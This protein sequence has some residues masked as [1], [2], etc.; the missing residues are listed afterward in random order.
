MNK[1]SPD[2]SLTDHSEWPS[3]AEAHPKPLQPR[4]TTF[5]GPGT[6][7]WSGSS[8]YSPFW[9]WQ[10]AES[11]SEAAELIVAKF[12]RLWARNKKDPLSDD[13]ADLVWNFKPRPNALS[14]DPND[15]G[16]FFNGCF[17]RIPTVKQIREVLESSPDERTVGNLG[18][19]YTSCLDG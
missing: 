7:R 2:F 18:S 6:F 3:L 13:D 14:N 12:I 9:I 17:V 19:G 1:G 4:K 8:G 10:F 5:K 16:V 11:E 15:F